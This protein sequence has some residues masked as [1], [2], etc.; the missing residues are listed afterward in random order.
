MVNI[1]YTGI[2]P[3]FSRTYYL[4]ISR[5]RYIRGF[6]P[7]TVRILLLLNTLYIYI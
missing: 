5:K 2:Y 7:L 1:Y 4:F 3:R 6:N